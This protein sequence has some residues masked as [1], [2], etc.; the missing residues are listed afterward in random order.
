M[1]VLIL[2][3]LLLALSITSVAFAG[4]KADNISWVELGPSLKYVDVVVGEGAEVTNRSFVSMH[5]TGWLWENGQKTSKFDSSVD[6]GEVFSVNLG[7]G[8]VIQ[9]WDKGVP[10]MKVGG[11]RTVVIGYEMAYGEAGRPPEIPA[12]ADLVFDIEVTALPEV[13]VEI[14]NDGSGPEIKIGD[15][16]NVHYTGWIWENDAKG[17][18]F[19]SSLDRGRPFSLKLGA[20]QVIPGWEM[21]LKGLKIG[22]KANITIPPVLAYGSRGAGNVIPP[23]ATLIFEVEIM[24]PSAVSSLG[25]EVKVVIL[26]EGSGAVAAAGDHIHVHYTGWLWEN[27]TKGK[28]FDSSLSRGEPIQFD[29]GTGRVIKGWDQGLEGLKVG[30]KARL[31]IP[32][33]LGYGERGS[34][35]AIP[36]NADLCF[37]VELVGITGK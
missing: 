20:G 35:G 8:R 11:K 13:G 28:Q 23:N 19:D 14:L 1:K 18:R 17:N 32:A 29:L 7:L 3:V 21:G 33:A 9:G 12:S 10:G 5:Y 2:T 4:D 6:R 16:I 36:P 22:S 37:D 25:N 31:L 30:T 24:E 27:E 26:S 15:D 34:G